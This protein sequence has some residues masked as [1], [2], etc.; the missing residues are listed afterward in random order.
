MLTWY[1]AFVDWRLCYPHFLQFAQHQDR[2]YQEIREVCGNETVTEEHLP[3]LPYLNAVFQETLRRHAPVPI[4]PP[5]F[6]HENT[7]LAGYD[8]PAGTEVIIN[9]NNDNQSTPSVPNYNSQIWP[10]VLFKNFTQIFLNLNYFWRTCIKQTIT[11]KWY[12][13]QNFCIRR[14][15]K[16][17][18]VR[19]SNEL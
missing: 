15:V 13:A 8:V 19:K 12:F 1:A 10:L 18:G 14:E 7:S 17:L 5:R 9:H 3:R 2:L 4:L 6:V 16:L 11:K